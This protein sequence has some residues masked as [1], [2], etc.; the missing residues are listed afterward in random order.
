M[1]PGFSATRWMLF[2]MAVAFAAYVAALS[3]L[4]GPLGIHGLWIALW[5]FYG[6]RGTGLALAYPRLIPAAVDR[7]R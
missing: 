2:T 7:N 6:L 1:Y 5:L 4:P 3:L